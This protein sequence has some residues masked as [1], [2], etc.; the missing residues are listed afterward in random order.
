[1]TSEDYKGW[2]DN[3]LHE[4]LDLSDKKRIE[5]CNGNQ[6]ND[7]HTNFKVISS[8]LG[9]TPMQVLSVYLNKHIESLSSFFK[10]GNTYSDETIESRVSDII[11]YLL[12]AMSMKADED[13][14]KAS[15]L[16]QDR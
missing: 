5:Y 9:L 8:K 10:T 7:V 12:L 11:N 6:Y 15:D 14:K 16:P 13:I 2:R 4:T 3:F 1:M